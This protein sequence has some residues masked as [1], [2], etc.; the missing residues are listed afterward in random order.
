[1]LDDYKERD[2]EPP[3][4]SEDYEEDFDSINDEIWLL[5]KEKEEN[6]H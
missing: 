1:M 6:E 4:P 3:E 5:K 2:M